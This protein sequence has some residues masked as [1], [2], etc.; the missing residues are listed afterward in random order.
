M[1][2][3]PLLT[4]NQVPR[5]LTAANIAF[6][7]VY[8]VAIA[9]FFKIGNPYLFGLLIFGEAFHLFQTISYALTI[10]QLDK[11][12]LPDQTFAEPVDVMI[13]VAG[14]PL[15]IVEET[16]RAA[17]AMDYPAHTVWILNDSRVANKD[18]WKDYQ[19]NQSQ[20]KI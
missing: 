8:F 20:F 13:T 9:F 3:T 5:F 11:P 1:E 18:N 4:V 7:V 10:W 2:K 12:A 15:D 16:A 17:K 14:E 19:N 6:A